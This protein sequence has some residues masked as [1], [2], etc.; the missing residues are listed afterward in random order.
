MLVRINAGLI[1]VK[2]QYFSHLLFHFYV[3]LNRCVGHPVS[4]IFCVR[5]YDFANTEVRV[6][7]SACLRANIRMLE[8]QRPHVGAPTSACSDAY[9]CMYKRL[10]ADVENNRFSPGIF[11]Y[12][13]VH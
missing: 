9:L 6:S 11:I 4:N 3:Y 10:T 12:I 13:S 1:C 8:L 7:T 5:I 2:T